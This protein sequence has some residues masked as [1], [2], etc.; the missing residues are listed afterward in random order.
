M[1]DKYDMELDAQ[2]SLAEVNYKCE[3]KRTERAEYYFGRDYSK[4]YFFYWICSDCGNEI[5]SEPDEA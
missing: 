3:H 2:P 5:E 1:P 4:D